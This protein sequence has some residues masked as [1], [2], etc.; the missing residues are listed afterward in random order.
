MK[1]TEFWPWMKMITAALLIAFAVRHFLFTPIIVDGQSMMPT[2]HHEDRMIVNKIGY[3]VTEPE[4]FDIIVFHAEAGK[5]YI[6]RVIGLPGDVISYQNDILL[7]NGEPL[8]EQY[9]EEYQEQ[10]DSLPFTHDFELSDVTLFEEIPEDHLF[11][12][13]DNRQFSRDSRHIGMVAYEEIVGTADVVFWPFE[14]ARF[15]H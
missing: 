7:V 5:D 2:L 13:G 11:V 8:P 6:K 1:D 3:S 10:T 12:M 4:R 9:L 14:G 15:V